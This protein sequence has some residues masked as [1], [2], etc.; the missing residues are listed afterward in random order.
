MTYLTSSCS[1]YRRVFDCGS[2]YIPKPVNESSSIFVSR[3]N[4]KVTT[5]CNFLGPRLSRRGEGGERGGACARCEKAERCI[6]RT[7]TKVILMVLIL[8]CGMTPCETRPLSRR[9]DPASIR[10]LPAGEPPCRRVEP[11]PTNQHPG[12]H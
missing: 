7:M 9:S 5:R 4:Q 11:A 3:K 1:I 12:P 8:A 6:P 10:I 2:T